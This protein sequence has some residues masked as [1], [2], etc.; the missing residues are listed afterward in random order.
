MTAAYDD[1]VKLS[2][3]ILVRSIFENA[4]A[5]MA[6]L[7]LDGRVLRV[8]RALCDLLRA[9]ERYLLSDEFR[10]VIFSNDSEQ[11]TPQIS[12][13]IAGRIRCFQR[14]KEYV[15]APGRSIWILVTVLLY[16]KQ[17]EP[18]HLISQI[19]DVSDYKEVEKEKQRLAHQL[20]ERV[21]E[22]RAVHDIARLLHDDEN[23]TPILLQ[24]IVA[25]LPAAWKN[26]ELAGARIVFDG[27][28]YKSQNFTARGGTQSAYFTTAGGKNGRIEITYPDTGAD[29]AKPSFLA[30]ERN[31]LDSLT[32]MLMLH[33]DR[34]EARDRI[35]GITRELIERNKELWSL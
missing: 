16:D 2:S 4:P 17:R 15:Y 30:Q 5:G 25:L 9:D 10:G 35:D 13:L 1:K 29:Q 18:L 32:E 22:L 23:P 19:Q 34:K 31:L 7:G 14:E 11:D 27:S 6:L 28:E 8:N 12:D 21:K 3:S 24:E 33:L 20:N 26:A